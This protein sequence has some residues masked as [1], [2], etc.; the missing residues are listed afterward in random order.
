MMHE[1]GALPKRSERLAQW[2][3]PSLRENI[4]NDTSTLDQRETLLIELKD[5]FMAFYVNVWV[6]FTT[7]GPC[8]VHE[9]DGSPRKWRRILWSL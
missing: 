8:L 7:E 3:D 4:D 6:D 5:W 1:A 2:E 9:P